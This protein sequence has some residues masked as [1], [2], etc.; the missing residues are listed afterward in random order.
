MRLF[1]IKTFN[2]VEWLI[3][4]EIAKIHVFEYEKFKTKSCSTN[5]IL[6]IHRSIT[7]GNILNEKQFMSLD[8]SN[9]TT[10]SLEILWYYHRIKQIY[11]ILWYYYHFYNLKSMLL[12]WSLFLN[13]N[14]SFMLIKLQ[15][16]LEELV[17]NLKPIK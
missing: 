3:S 5:C 16:K 11:F 4:F 1:V 8:G 14:F 17:W 2:I 6:S 15:L 7:N 9:I 13:L 10:L 12:Y